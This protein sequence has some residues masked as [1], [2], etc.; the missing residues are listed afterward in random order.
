MRLHSE[1]RADLDTGALTGIIDVRTPGTR[2]YSERISSSSSMEIVW[3]PTFRQT[4]GIAQQLIR[5]RGSPQDAEL[6]WTPCTLAPGCALATMR[7]MR[8]ILGQ[9]HSEPRWGRQRFRLYRPN[10]RAIAYVVS[11]LDKAST[12]VSHRLVEDEGARR[13]AVRKARTRVRCARAHTECRNR[14]GT[15]SR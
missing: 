3:S 8:T 7:H 10:W 13:I 14:C 1:K 11:Q 12:D 15:C 6:K 2:E 9:G 5:G 4:G